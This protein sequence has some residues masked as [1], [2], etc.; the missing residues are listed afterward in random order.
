MTQAATSS[1]NKTVSVHGGKSR[2]PKAKTG[3]AY[4]TLN[5]IPD[6]AVVP[7]LKQ[8]R[9]ADM[10]ESHIRLTATKKECEDKIK[11]LQIEIEAALVASGLEKVTYDGRPVQVVN[12]T[13]G[14]RVVPEKLLVAGVAAETIA[15][16]TEPGKEYSY[17]LVGKQ[18][19]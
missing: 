7:E 15:E 13:S 8:L 16:C 9:F 18:G 10:V 17:V 6:W 5:I 3:D 4:A 12:A 2:K 1:K 14:A 11:K 19:K